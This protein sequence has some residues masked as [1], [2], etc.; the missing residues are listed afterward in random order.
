MVIPCYSYSNAQLIPPR[1]M[2]DL[3]RQMGAL[4]R[5]LGISQG[6]LAKRIGKSRFTVIK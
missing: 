2:K 4:R 5:D 6:D 1:W 3:G